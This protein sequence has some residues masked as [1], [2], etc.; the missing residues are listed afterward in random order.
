MLG[1]YDNSQTEFQNNKDWNSASES[2]VSGPWFSQTEFQNNKD[3]N[4]EFQRLNHYFLEI[5]QTEFQNNKDWNLF[6]VFQGLELSCSQTEFQ[7]NKD[8]NDATAEA[9]SKQYGTHRPN[10]KTTRIETRN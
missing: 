4:F 5:S 8:W 3:W 2:S 6:C 10:S 9:I 7:N 1:L